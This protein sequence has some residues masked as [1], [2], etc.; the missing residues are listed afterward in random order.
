MYL[1]EEMQD[2]CLK[3]LSLVSTRHQSVWNIV[4]P[5]DMPMQGFSMQKSVSVEIILRQPVLSGQILIVIWT[6]KGINKTNVGAL[7]G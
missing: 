3:E 5:R 7:T 6:V 1:I 4:R 2:H